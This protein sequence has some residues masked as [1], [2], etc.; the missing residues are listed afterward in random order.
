VF[1]PLLKEQIARYSILKSNKNVRKFI[2]FNIIA[3]SH[4]VSEKSI[5][6]EP[7]GMACYIIAAKFYASQGILFFSIKNKLFKLKLLILI[8]RP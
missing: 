4:F 2:Y 3:A 6:L 1:F 8:R 5:N 7:H